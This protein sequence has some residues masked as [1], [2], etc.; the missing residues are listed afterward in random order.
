MDNYYRIKADQ[1]Q[2]AAL[3][4]CIACAMS[5]LPKVKGRIKMVDHVVSYI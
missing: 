5:F 2:G 1:L 4:R 3:P